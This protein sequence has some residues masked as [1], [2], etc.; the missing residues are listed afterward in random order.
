MKYVLFVIAFVAFISC[1]KSHDACGGGNPKD[2]TICMDGTLQ[3]SGPVEADGLGW[4]LKLN[5]E[6]HT[7]YCLK[8]PSTIFPKNMETAVHI[9]IYKTKDKVCSWGGCF[10]QYGI[11][12][13]NKK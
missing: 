3:W 2:S 10:D 9:C 4:T 1:N 5:N 11:K 7:F 13:I 8:E 12:S 6:Q